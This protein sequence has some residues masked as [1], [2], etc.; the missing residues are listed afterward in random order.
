MTRN[1]DSNERL[2]RELQAQIEQLK[3]KLLAEGNNGA[4]ANNQ[5]AGTPYLIHSSLLVSHVDTLP[6]GTI[7]ATELGN[8]KEAARDGAVAEGGLGG[9]GA[10]VPSTGICNMT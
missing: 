5:A 1:E 2:I 6:F 9:E 4:A 3:L 10:A 8:R 7:R